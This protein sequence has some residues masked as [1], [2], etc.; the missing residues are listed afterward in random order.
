MG[1]DCAPVTVQFRFFNRE[2]DELIGQENGFSPPPPGVDANTICHETQVIT[3]NNSD[4]FDSPN[5]AN[6]D[7]TQAGFNSGWMRL[8]F[9]DAGD[10]S[11]GPYTFTGL[12]VIGFA[13]T[14]LENGT[15]GSAVLN[16]G[17]LWDHGYVTE[18]TPQNAP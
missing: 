2:E 7:L 5:D 17:M 13:A 1:D 11:A 10:L 15:N 12:P 3:F 9:P 14:S 4:L 6:V 8:E 16:Y 18:I